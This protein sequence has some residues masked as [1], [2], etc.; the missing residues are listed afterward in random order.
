MS[1]PSLPPQWLRCPSFGIGDTEGGGTNSILT[2]AT[3]TNELSHNTPPTDWPLA[4]RPVCRLGNL[5]VASVTSWHLIFDASPLGVN[6]DVLRTS[7]NC[8]ILVGLGA[9]DFVRQFNC[10]IV[11]VECFVLC[12][13]DTSQ[14]NQSLIAV[15]ATRTLNNRSKIL[16]AN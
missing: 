2:P 8:N 10:V 6:L 1:P 12:F 14:W 13:S 16:Q 5:P 3:T 4:C 15:S 9:M 7:C 11:V